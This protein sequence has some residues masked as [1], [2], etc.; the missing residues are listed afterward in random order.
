M[1]ANTSCISLVIEA[2]RQLYCSL[3]SF[4]SCWF[5]PTSTTGPDYLIVRRSIRNGVAWNLGLI[6]NCLVSG[7]CEVAFFIV[8]IVS[9]GWFQIALGGFGPPGQQWR[10]EVG[11]F[12]WLLQRRLLLGLRE[13]Q[14]LEASTPVQRPMCF[15]GYL[16]YMPTYMSPTLFCFSDWL[17]WNL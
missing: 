4:T 9:M 1:G 6:N 16:S 12:L 7:M 3:F 13:R 5:D 15:C 8:A 2:K 14:P 10:P 17:Q 11:H